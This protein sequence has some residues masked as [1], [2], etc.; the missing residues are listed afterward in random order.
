MLKYILSIY[1]HHDDEN[2]G[3]KLV[4]E[5]D[6]KLDVK[7]KLKIKVYLSCTE[8]MLTFYTNI[9]HLPLK[10]PLRCIVSSLFYR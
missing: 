10:S 7:K 4:A 2:D 8:S 1:K 9:L 5:L 6:S 3:G